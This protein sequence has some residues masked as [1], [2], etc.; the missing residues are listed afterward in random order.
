V[1]TYAV[2][3]QDR[4]ALRRYF[5]GAGGNRL[6]EWQQQGKYAESLLLFGVDVNQDLWDALLLL[7]FKD[8]DQYAAWKETERD[9]PAGLSGDVL[10]LTTGVT[11]TLAELAWRGAPPAGRRPGKAP[12]YF[13]RPYYFT[14]RTMYE[15]FFEAYN[16]PQFDVWLRE[17]ALSRY[18][19]LV[20]SN[21]SGGAWGVLLIYEYPDWEAASGRASLKGSVGD[22]L[23]RIPGW[24]LLG[25]LKSNVR[26]SGRVSLAEALA[27]PPPKR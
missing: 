13:V 4:P 2:K 25:Q 24:E 17:S 8:W 19:A 12:V 1:L 7:H 22:E 14:D 27:L 11:S 3:P 10:A 21:S 26:Q 16:K 6:S 20:N 23:R 18:W 9:F 5:L 15:R